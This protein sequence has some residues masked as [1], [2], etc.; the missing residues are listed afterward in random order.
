M[1]RPAHRELRGGTDTDDVSAGA[2]EAAPRSLSVLTKVAT[3]PQRAP[4]RRAA[5]RWLSTLGLGRGL[6]PHSDETHASGHGEFP[7]LPHTDFDR[8]LAH[9]HPSGESSQRESRMPVVDGIMNFEAIPLRSAESEPG[10]SL[11][12]VPNSDSNAL[13]DE[14][15]DGPVDAEKEEKLAK[16]NESFDFDGLWKR[17]SEALTRL[18]ADQG[19][20]QV[21]LPLIE[22]RRRAR[23]TLTRR[24]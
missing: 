5:L 10:N 8:V 3:V 12:A 11:L 18:Q 13:M 19:S 23:S 24:A 21:L 2:C 22:V 14:A 20:A 1:R 7:Q 4:L 17:L 6:T 9:L 16:V 15:D